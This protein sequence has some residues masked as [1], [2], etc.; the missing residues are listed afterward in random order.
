MG[1]NA[2]ALGLG[3]GDRAPDFRGLLGTDGGRYSLSSFEDAR[4]LVVLFISNGCPTVR[5]YEDRLKALQ[6]AYRGSGV[7]LVAINSNNPYL[8]PGDTHA[9]MVKRAREQALDFAYLKDEDRSVAKAYGAVCTPHAFLFDEQRRLRY[10]G[11]IDDARVPTGVT[12][13]DL[14]N[15]LSDLLAGRTPE[16]PITP[17]FGCAIVW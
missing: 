8:S 16:V 1:E 9:E 17:P 15:A 10:R 7:R 4:L 13:R 3:L 2:A 14:E 12:A 6:Q 5:A 11:R